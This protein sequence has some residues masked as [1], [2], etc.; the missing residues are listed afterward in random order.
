LCA[1]WD[2]AAS[3]IKVDLHFGIFTGHVSGP[4]LANLS[5]GREITLDGEGNPDS[6]G[7]GNICLPDGKCTIVKAKIQMP[8]KDAPAG[9]RGTLTVLPWGEM[10]EIQ[11]IIEPKIIDGEKVCG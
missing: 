9:T 4:D 5:M 10:P 1:P 6:T 7:F 8:A 2:G 11:Y 3:T